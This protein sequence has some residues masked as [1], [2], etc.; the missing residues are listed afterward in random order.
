MSNLDKKI[1]PLRY[2]ILILDTKN[3]FDWKHVDDTPTHFLP[4]RTWKFIGNT[5]IP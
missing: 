4:G 1:T 3:D 5:T 2:Y